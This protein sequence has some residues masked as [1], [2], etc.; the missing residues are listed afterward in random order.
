MR[1][2]RHYLVMARAKDEAAFK[3]AYEAFRTDLGGI[4]MYR[5][6]MH[7][8]IS[9]RL[10]GNLHLRNYWLP[11]EQRERMVGWFE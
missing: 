11:V 8:R 3:A 4:D 5:V 6:Y 10:V 9:E 2:Q 7:E 1:A